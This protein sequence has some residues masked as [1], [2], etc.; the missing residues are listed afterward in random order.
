MTASLLM[1]TVIP[2]VLSKGL[3]EE[4]IEKVISFV[5]KYGK[6][7]TDKVLA[8]LDELKKCRESSNGVVK[9]RKVPSDVEEEVTRLL[10]EALKDTAR[11]V[12]MDGV[13]FFCEKPMDKETQE[14]LEQILTNF[15]VGLEWEEEQQTEYQAAVDNFMDAYYGGC[16]PDKDEDEYWIGSDVFYLNFTIHDI[17]DSYLCDDAKLRSLVDAINHLL[18]EKYITGYTPY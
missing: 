8:Y 17:T 7:F 18:G 6:K 15:D 11:P 3:T 10:I 16:S 4:N 13:A 12:Y 14:L 9:G 2:A 5:A 1:S